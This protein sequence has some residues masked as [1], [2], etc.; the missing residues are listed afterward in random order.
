MVEEIKRPNERDYNFNDNLEGARF[1]KDMI[2]YADHLEKRIDELKE[3]V[4]SAKLKMRESLPDECL[5]D[6]LWD[7]PKFCSHRYNEGNMCQ[8]CVNE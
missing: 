4:A 3:E 6:H 5:Q 8:F 1:A 7:D 2:R